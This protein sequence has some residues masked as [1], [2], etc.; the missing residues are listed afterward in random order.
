MSLF[1]SLFITSLAV[2]E[3]LQIRFFCFFVY[4]RIIFLQFLWLVKWSFQ[5]DNINMCQEVYILLLLIDNFIPTNTDLSI[6]SAFI[7]IFSTQRHTDVANKFLKR[8]MTKKQPCHWHTE[9]KRIYIIA[10]ATK[11]KIKKQLDWTSS[12]VTNVKGKGND[13]NPEKAK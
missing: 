5:D 2:E 8:K 12:I 10:F 4:W 1:T 3:L 11:N 7:C 6:F 13:G 9:K